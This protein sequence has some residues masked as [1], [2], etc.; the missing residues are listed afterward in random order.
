ME[1]TWTYKWV[2]NVCKLEL[3]AETRGGGLHVVLQT[4]QLTLAA[5]WKAISH[6]IVLKLHCTRFLSVYSNIRFLVSYEKSKIT[7][8]SHFH[9]NPMLWALALF[10]Y[11]Y[12][13]L[14]QKWIWILKGILFYWQIDNK[15]KA[16]RP[17]SIKIKL[18]QARTESLYSVQNDPIIDIYLLK[19]MWTIN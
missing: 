18:S 4:T 19:P 11:V 5:S 8:F 17:H 7:P 3:L 1:F 6:L 10:S 13:N 14:N 12:K 15:S 16:I 9:F 2:D